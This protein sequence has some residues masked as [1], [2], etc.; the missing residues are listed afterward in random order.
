MTYHAAIRRIFDG[1]P[2][3]RRS[4][5]VVVELQARWPEVGWRLSTVRTIL[6]ALCVHHTSRPYQPSYERH[7]FLR[8]VR[9]GVY[10]PAVLVED[11]RAPLSSAASGSAAAS[12]AEEAT[13]ARRARTRRA[14][15]TVMHAVG[16]RVTAGLVPRLMPRDARCASVRRDLIRVLVEHIETEPFQAQYRRRPVGPVVRGWAERLKRYFWPTP[17]DGLSATFH[18]MTPWFER[19]GVLAA[20]LD[21][22]EA[23]TTHDRAAATHLAEAVLVWGGVPQRAGTTPDVV[24]AV[25]QR[26]LGRHVHPEPPMNSGWTKVA[27]LATAFLETHPERHPHVIW[28]SRVSA[29][30]IAR[31]DALM[32]RA[33][34]GDPSAVFPGIGTVPGRGGTRATAP[35]ATRLRLRWPNGYRSWRTQDAGSA[36][37]REVRDVLNTEGYP[38]MPVG[39]GTSRLWT[40]RGVESVLFMDGY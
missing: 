40:I 34:E 1:D 7:A 15:P 38:R 31:L 18:T 27:A 36:L 10:Q 35:L 3:P 32:L 8:R 16:W 24:E 6:N 14:A 9:R 25:V 23:W 17:S 12:E 2:R 29:S 5:E 13:A 39:D 28:D 20:A 19:A 22:G 30:I 37:V 11:G 4:E 26:A 21:R 33:G